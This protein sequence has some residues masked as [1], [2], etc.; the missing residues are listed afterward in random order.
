MTLG[1]SRREDGL[2]EDRMINA[3]R[4]VSA[5]GAFLAAWGSPAAQEEPHYVVTVSLAVS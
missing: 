1:D 2:T 5:A 3:M 4:V